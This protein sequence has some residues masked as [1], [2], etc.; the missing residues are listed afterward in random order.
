MRERALCIDF[1]P[2]CKNYVLHI[3]EALSWDFSAVTDGNSDMHHCSVCEET[4]GETST[5]ARPLRDVS[6]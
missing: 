1:D 4:E 5:S 2:A 3:F 6:K